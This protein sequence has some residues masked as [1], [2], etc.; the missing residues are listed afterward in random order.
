MHPNLRKEQFSLAFVH[1]AAAAAGAKVQRAN[2]DDDSVDLEVI[3]PRT[4]GPSRRSPHL[5]I[6]AKATAL[7]LSADG[8]F[9]CSLSRKNYEDLSDPHV[10]VP[11]ILVVVCL[12]ADG[13]WL[14][15]SDERWILRRTAYWHSLRG[16]PALDPPALSTTVHIPRHQRFGPEVLMELLQT[17][18]RGEYP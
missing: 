18:A 14:D 10:H 2:V 17:V 9:S 5:A 8:T 16:S 3:G 12:P 11:V 7:E 4:L 13:P 6:Q 15:T 1:A